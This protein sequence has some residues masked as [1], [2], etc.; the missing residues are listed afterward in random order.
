[1]SFPYTYFKGY[2][3]SLTKPWLR[4][5]LQ[6]PFDQKQLTEFVRSYYI[7]S[8][9]ASHSNPSTAAADILTFLRDFPWS[10]LRQGS[11]NIKIM[12]QSPGTTA[13]IA[14]FDSLTALIDLNLGYIMIIELRYG[15]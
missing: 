7:L 14:V 4:Q 6:A 2:W 1:M 13:Q 5:K 15:C 11:Q 12:E 9:T 10:D 8:V 3:S